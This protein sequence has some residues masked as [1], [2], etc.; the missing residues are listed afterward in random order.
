MPAQPSLS[1]TVVKN[2]SANLVRLAGSGIVALLLPPF[3]VRMLPTET[4]SAWALLLQ[5][6]LYVSLLDFGIQTA[7]ARFVAHAQ[8]LHDPEQRDGSVST[9]AVLLVVA[10]FVAFCFIAILAWQLPRVFNGMPA[11]LDHEA[12]IALLLMGGSFALGLPFSVIH[13]VFIGL[14]RN[15]IPAAIVVVNRFAMA[16]L[17]VGVVFRH[18]GLASMGLA[19]AI[20]N[21]ASYGGSYLAWRFF[22]PHIR[23]RLSLVSTVCAKNIAGYSLALAAWFAG[24][25][26]VSGLDLA[27]VAKFDYPAT[28]YYAVAATLIGFVAQT[29]GAIF[30]SLLPA[31]AILSARGDAK[32]LGEVLITS[33][34]YGMFI[35]LGMALPLIVAGR[36]ILRLWVGTD[37]AM[38]STGIL[39]VLVVANVVRLCALPYATLLLGT[40]Q[41]RK[42]IMSPLAEGVT[43][44]SAS[45]LGALYLGAIGVAI[46]TLIGSFV[47]MGLHLLHNMPRT[48]G[49]AFSRFEFIKQGLLRPLACSVP[50]FAL[51]LVGVNGPITS[52]VAAVLLCLVAIS[53]TSFLFW[54]YGLVGPDRQRLR[55]AFHPSRATETAAKALKPANG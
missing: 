15:E 34:R 11:N 28:A 20:A 25:L 10:A 26:M 54:N 22:A 33:T 51:L 29:Q 2:A 43:N 50:F 18:W 24:M 3:L 37:Y 47:G 44:L 46:G 49:I 1:R 23:I 42:V 31:S 14:Q 38:H 27:I 21:L 53:G 55:H 16:A 52:P 7:V 19:V 8:E 41:Q 5:L 12:R 4:Y 40:N 36:F 9:A 48:S 17:T 30:A 32:K 13:A 6:T 45:L 39:Q 35:L